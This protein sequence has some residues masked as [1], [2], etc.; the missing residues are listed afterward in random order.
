L[1]TLD[2]LVTQEEALAREVYPSKF[3]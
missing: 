3:A 1:L 2:S